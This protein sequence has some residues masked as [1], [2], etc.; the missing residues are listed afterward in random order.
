LLPPTYFVN[1]VH[2]GLY[3]LYMLPY[4][5]VTGG[6]CLLYDRLTTK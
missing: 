5:A 1:G 2:N 3:L 6:A 4:I